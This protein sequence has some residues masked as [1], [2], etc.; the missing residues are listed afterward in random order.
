MLT[1][2]LQRVQNYFDPSLS[3]KK[4]QPTTA[5]PTSQPTQLPPPTK[6][7]RT[8]KLIMVTAENNNKYYEM[9]EQENDT[10]TVHYGRVGGTKSVATYPIAQ[11]NKKFREKVAK[12]YV[13]QTH[14][15]ADTTVT[16][17]A[18]TIADP[19]VRGLMSRLMDFANQSIY[20]NY[21]VTAQQVTRKQVETAQQL[22]DELAKLVALGVDISA[23][24]SKLLDLF[25]VIP[26]KMGKVG[27]HLVAQ[28]PQTADELQTLHT[29]LA[30]EQD[31]LDVMRGQVELAQ[32][33]TDSNLPPP[34][35]L[36]T[37]N[38]RVEP[39]TD[40]RVLNLIKQMMGPDVD[41][42]DAAFS[43]QQAATQ[44]AFD[45]HIKQAKKP[46]TQLLW[47]GSR[48]EN[49][50][51]ILKTG[52]VLRPANAVIT[53][54]M[55]G[56]GIYFADQF[57]KS[58]NY[59]SLHG[60]VWANGKQREGYLGIYEVHVGEQ[61]V[62]SQHEARYQL[63]DSDTLKRINPAYD[64]VF[65]QRGVSLLKNEFIVYNQAQCTVR[66]MVKIKI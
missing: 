11:W 46:K 9:H 59:T 10:F 31:T 48:S 61:M 51:S 60:S 42:F 38:L 14:L 30:S 50:M 6:S 13:D 65:A 58:L 49:W 34:G 63:L 43:V 20:Q 3:L 16:S 8:L 35:L 25:K 28:V 23:Y 64:S 5:C 40:Q 12:G 21:V 2:L 62:V 19:L 15:Y 37:M 17:D 56:Y 41:K 27:Q 18:S 29:Q 32:S 26:R 24:N 22:L 44:A 45:V 7:F 53:G 57:S 33:K 4:L 52:L 47:H 54:K 1:N 55:F 36:E 39:V 66:Y